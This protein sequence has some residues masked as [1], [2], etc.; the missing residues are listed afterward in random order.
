MFI[1]LFLCSDTVS[2]IINIGKQTEEKY[3]KNII[4]NVKSPKILKYKLIMVQIRKLFL[5]QTF[6]GLKSNILKNRMGGWWGGLI[7]LRKLYIISFLCS[8][9]SLYSSVVYLEQTFLPLYIY[10]QK[11]LQTH[12]ILIYSFM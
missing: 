8:S 10:I 9:L 3:L 12:N 4:I 1:L 5:R 6:F 11:F 7:I 2:D